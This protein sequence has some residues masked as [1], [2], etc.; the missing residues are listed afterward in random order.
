M[1]K[2]NMFVNLTTENLNHRNPQASAENVK[3]ILNI[4]AEDRSN[5]SVYD[6]YSNYVSRGMDS[7][8]YYYEDHRIQLYRV[9]FF[10]LE[11]E[12]R[13]IVLDDDDT[14]ERPITFYQVPAELQE[15][16]YDD[17]VYRDYLIAR[18]RLELS[19]NDTDNVYRRNLL[20]SARVR[21][22]DL[23]MLLLIR[24]RSRARTTTASTV[25]ST[26]ISTISSVTSTTPKYEESKKGKGL[27]FRG[28]TGKC[29]LKNQQTS[30]DKFHKSSDQKQ[31]P[32]DFENFIYSQILIKTN[33]N[34]G[35]VTFTDDIRQALYREQMKSLFVKIL[36]S[37]PEAFS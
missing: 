34:Y 28:P 20:E 31:G 8:E 29:F 24:V 10:F 35:Y 14:S 1:M 16:L 26:T 9:L 3:R 27:I 15:I 23:I 17:D 4:H 37:V 21:E 11:L 25:F 36:S 22:E 19:L 13:G 32:S 7:M 5:H 30:N 18:K 12:D 33:D 6:H 2:F